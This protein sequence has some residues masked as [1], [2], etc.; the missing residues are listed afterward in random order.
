MRSNLL[1]L[2]HVAKFCCSQTADDSFAVGFAGMTAK[3]KQ[4]PVLCCVRYLWCPEFKE[5]LYLHTLSMAPSCYHRLS[6]LCIRDMSYVAMQ[7]E[8]W[9]TLLKQQL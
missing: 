4:R 3:R 2:R 5:L 8:A 6:R 9:K 7:M 1:V